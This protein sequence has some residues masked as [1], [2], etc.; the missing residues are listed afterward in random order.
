MFRFAPVYIVVF[1]LFV[2]M[3]NDGTFPSVSAQSKVVVLSEGN[4]DEIVGKG[5]TFI[6]FYAP[7]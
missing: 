1:V 4:F 2:G 6:K 3:L 7:W 5:L